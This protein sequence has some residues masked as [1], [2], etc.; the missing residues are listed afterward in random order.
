MNLQKRD[1]PIN[2]EFK[3]CVSGWLDIVV[4]IEQQKFDAGISYCMGPSLDNL[5]ESLLALNH[6]YP[7]HKCDKDFGKRKDWL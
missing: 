4:N 2:F 6:K 3:R 1:C 7:D 5:V